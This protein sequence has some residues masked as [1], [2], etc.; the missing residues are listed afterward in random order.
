MAR[1]LYQGHGSFRIISKDNIVIYFDPYAGTGYDVP[2]D[3]ILVTHQH[4]DHNQISLVEKKQDCTILQERDALKE[5]GYQNFGIK[6]IHIQAVPAYNKNHSR[7]ESVGYI[8]TV[9]DIKVY[10]TG[11]T[12]ITEE[13][14]ELAAQSLDYVLLPTDGIYNMG[15]EEAAICAELL[16]AKAAIPI[17]MKPGELFSIEMAERFTAKNRKIVRDGEEIIL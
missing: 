17:H 16:E 3:I 7:A 4:G 8:I 6:G 10:G 11:D 5:G 15:P 9:D 13:M 2:A 1:L 14:K 12:S